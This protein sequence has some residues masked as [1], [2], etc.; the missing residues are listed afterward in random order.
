LW[1]SEDQ[2]FSEKVA[3]EAISLDSNHSKSP[4]FRGCPPPVVGYAGYETGDLKAAP[5]SGSRRLRQIAYT[6][7]AAANFWKAVWIFLGVN[8]DAAIPA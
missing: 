6:R 2:D 5:K 7:P 8:I 1:N 3:F 4:H